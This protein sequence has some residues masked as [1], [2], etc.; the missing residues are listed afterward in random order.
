MLCHALVQL[1]ED[2]TF[3]KFAQFICCSRIHEFIYLYN[4]IY[5][6]LIYLYIALT[7]FAVGHSRPWHLDKLSLQDGKKHMTLQN[8]LGRTLGNSQA[9][10]DFHWQEKTLRREGVASN[11]NSPTSIAFV[12]H[13]PLLLF[14]RHLKGLD[15]YSRRCRFKL[16]STLR[17]FSQIWTWT[18][19]N[20]K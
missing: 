8:L 5:L 9:D 6:W 15:S 16:C 18:W 13:C 12:S 11:D 4:L 17:C 3:G 1:V 20:E 7:P 19:N 10:H 14:A 2:E